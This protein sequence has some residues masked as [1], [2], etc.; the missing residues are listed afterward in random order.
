MSHCGGL[1]KALVDKVRFFL[2]FFSFDSFMF[3][4]DRLGHAS[5]VTWS[6]GIHDTL[7]PWLLAPASWHLAR[8]YLRLFLLLRLLNT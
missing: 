4:G 2:F 6:P 5:T 7:T 1:D 3:L 8:L